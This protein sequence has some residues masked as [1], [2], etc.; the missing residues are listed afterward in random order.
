MFVH[1]LALLKIRAVCAKT[2]FY[3]EFHGLPLEQVICSRHYM[4]SQDSAFGLEMRLN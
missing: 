4:D 3:Y 1:L 2:S